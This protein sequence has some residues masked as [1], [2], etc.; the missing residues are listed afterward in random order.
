M[1]FG[2][3]T[4]VTLTAFI[5]LTMSIV[6]MFFFII[7]VCVCRGGGAVLLMYSYTHII[8]A[9]NEQGIENRGVSPEEHRLP[10]LP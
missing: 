8:N 1:S 2:Q 4:L 9:Y 3:L 6:F 10:V 7:F 5:E